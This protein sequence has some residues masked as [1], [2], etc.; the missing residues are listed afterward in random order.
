MYDDIPPKASTA[1][2]AV[3]LQKQKASV[4]LIKLQEVNLLKTFLIWLQAYMPTTIVIA[5]GLVHPL[6][7]CGQRFPTVGQGVKG[8]G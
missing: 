1:S 5:C 6:P 3:I 2:K 7:W 4:F 8:K